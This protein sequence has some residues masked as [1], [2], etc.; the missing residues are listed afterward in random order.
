MSSSEQYLQLSLNAWLSHHRKF[1]ELAETYY[2]PPSPQFLHMV[3]QNNLLYK[4][5]LHAY[6]KDKPDT[7][8]ISYIIGN[9]KGAD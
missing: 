6:G 9:N 4:N 2:N 1:L 3:K 8:F 5:L 7:E